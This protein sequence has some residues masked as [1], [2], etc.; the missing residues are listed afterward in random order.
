MGWNCF[1]YRGKMAEAYVVLWTVERCRWLQRI[2]DEGPIEVVFGGPHTSQ[3]SIAAVRQNDVI[4][5][6]AVLDGALRLIAQLTV[7]TVLSPER[8]VRERLGIEL[9][10]GE[11]WDTLFHDLKKSRP[12]VGHRV[13]ITCAD[14]AAVG[15][16]TNIRFDRSFPGD[17]LG[18]LRL[19]PK[20]GKE[21][22]LLGVVDDR[23]KNNFS[24]QGHVRR[25]SGHSAALFAEQFDEV[26]PA[27]GVHHQLPQLLG[28]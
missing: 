2:R 21:K 4:Y 8:F 27:S 24:L 17:A 1:Q 13:P 23:L 15:R 6:V 7:D 26:H 28:G 9:G 11:M 5:P 10:P 16:G 14:E 3:P 20:A 12:D 19:G 25:L 18:F 22:P